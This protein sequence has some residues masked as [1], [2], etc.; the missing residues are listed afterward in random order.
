MVCRALQAVRESGE[1]L[2]EPD[3]LSLLMTATALFDELAIKVGRPEIVLTALREAVELCDWAVAADPE[4]MER[5][6]PYR[7]RFY[8]RISLMTAQQNQ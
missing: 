8:H 7:D 3:A 5:I 2:R 4:L 6:R 1:D